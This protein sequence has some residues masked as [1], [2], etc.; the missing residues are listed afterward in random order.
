MEP[1]TDQNCNGYLKMLVLVVPVG[2]LV[3]LELYSTARTIILLLLKYICYICK[4][5]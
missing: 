1:T 5:S 4:L 2:A 3:I